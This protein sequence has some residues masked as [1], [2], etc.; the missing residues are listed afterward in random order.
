[1]KNKDNE[2]KKLTTPKIAY[3][4][5]G[6]ITLPV[7]EQQFRD[8]VTSLL[9]RPEAIEKEIPG[10]FELSRD[11]ILN[12]H[13][14]IEQRIHQQNDAKLV[15]FQAKI[16]Y[17]DNS[18]VSLN[19]F[20]SFAT[21]NEVKPLISIGVELSW[22]YLIKFQDKTVPER[23][24]ILLNIMAEQRVLRN[25]LRTE[26][27]TTTF[28]EYEMSST[29]SY[30]SF[31][32]R[33]TARTWGQDIA[34]M[35]SDHIR[36]LM[37]P[38]NLISDFADRN[39]GKIGLAIFIILFVSFFFAIKTWIASSPTAA[40]AQQAQKLITSQA[41]LDEK[42]NFLLTFIIRPQ[43]LRNDPT[44]ALIFGTILAIAG[45]IWVTS[46]ASK[47]IMSFVILTRQ[48]QDYKNAYD[49]R[50][51][52]GWRNFVGSILLSLVV[53]LLSNLVIQFIK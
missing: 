14:L 38:Q 40:F 3:S 52:K 1:M 4:N 35:L 39:S 43:D 47:E 51:M 2:D 17:K 41:T 12:F 30:F 13:H 20:E 21:Y 16:I 5:E 8:F 34:S 37:K 28:R 44:L 11:E 24:E 10:I 27:G 45:G 9:G 23:Q 22:V 36:S 26:P 33:H 18:S 48:T 15:Q 49:Q 50:V 42:V 53:S 7:S 46:L 25:V 29:N 31:T 6:F 32:I 19:S